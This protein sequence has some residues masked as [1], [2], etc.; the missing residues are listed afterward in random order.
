LAISTDGGQNYRNIRQQDY[1]FS[2]DGATFEQED[3]QIGVEGVTHL[4]LHVV[5]DKQGKPCYA[6]LT[7]LAVFT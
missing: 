6:T 5:P 4:R 2:P 7:T 1:T 3:W